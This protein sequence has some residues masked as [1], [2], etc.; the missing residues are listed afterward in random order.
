VR[1]QVTVTP[2]LRTPGGAFDLAL[3][4]LD[5]AG[6]TV[7]QAMLGPVQVQGRVRS[8]SLPPVDVPVDATFGNAIELVGFNS[9]SLI[10]NLHPGNEVAVTLIWRALAPVDADYTVT[11][12]LLGS[13]GRV[14]GQRDVPPLD[15]AAPTSTWS[16]GEVLTDTYRFTVA[17]EA[18]SGEYRLLAVMYL[19][20][21]GERLE[22]DGDSSGE[23]VV[24]LGT[25][26][27]Q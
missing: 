12:Q 27:L 22:V 10:S 4:L 23:N 2:T 24:E 16:P 11:V 3:T 5:S 13:D 6:R 14:Y 26:R 15:G 21:T 9:Q 7:G 17:T 1:S 18:K 25:N 20:E 19:P 8:F